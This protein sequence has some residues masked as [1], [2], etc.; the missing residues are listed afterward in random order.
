VLKISDM[1]VK[2]ESRYDAAA[3]N[4]NAFAVA[5]RMAMYV[6]EVKKVSLHVKYLDDIFGALKIMTMYYT[7][8]T[9]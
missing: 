4:K 5:L 1:S 9:T 6:L 2:L 8:I 3:K 7:H